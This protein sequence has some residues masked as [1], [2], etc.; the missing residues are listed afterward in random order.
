MKLS[1]D[2]STSNI[3]IVL[4]DNNNNYYSSKHIELKEYNN[5]IDKALFFK[6]I[7]ID[8]NLSNL[9][10]IYIEAPLSSTGVNINT[11]AL[12]LSFNGM[13]NYICYEV[14]NIKPELITLHEARK[15]FLPEFIKEKINKKTNEVKETLSFPKNMKTKDKKEYIYNKVKELNIKENNYNEEIK[16]IKWF[17]NKRTGTI[18][19]RNFDISDSYIIMLGGLENNKKK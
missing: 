15:N 17:K 7:L 13:C 3:G 4:F 16:L 6:N 18:D 1:L 19:E 11:T 12:L 14:F 2:I 8:L 5:L 9:T 10:D